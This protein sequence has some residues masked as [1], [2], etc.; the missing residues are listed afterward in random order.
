L[1]TSIEEIKSKD[2]RVTCSP[3]HNHQDTA[4]YEVATQLWFDQH[5]KQSFQLPETPKLKLF[6]PSGKLPVVTLGVDESSE[7][8]AINVFYT[9][10]AQTDGGKDN[11]NNTK[12]RFWHYSA[13]SKNNG[14]WA[15]HLHLFSV[16]KPL[17]VYANVSYNL[18]KPISGAGYYY[19]I[20]SAKQFTLSSLMRVAT[21]GEL[22]KAGV[23]STLTPQVLIEDFKGD[24]QKEWFSY[25]PKKWG[26]KTHKLYHPAWAP[27]K[28]A[29][30]YFEIK[31]E[32]PNK[33]IVGLDQN[34][35]ELTLTGNNKWQG[36][37]LS[38][39][40]FKNFEMKPRANWAGIMEL[41]LDDEETLR[42]PRN[43]EEKARKLGAKW[44]GSPPEFRYL[45]W[46]VE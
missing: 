13:V 40:D 42:P 34:L 19:G 21:S 32:L 41:R 4:E 24:W 31:A 45:R 36:V 15:A 44:K 39:S 22:K 23:V 28:R 37:K 46:L 8:S 9:Q 30:L 43:S 26:I 18:K 38:P 14:K 29:K 11:S 17:W 12:N 2:W 10:Q 25:N 5:L 3:H 27:P 33:M 16:D 35:A 7:I 20:Y 1:E 6:L